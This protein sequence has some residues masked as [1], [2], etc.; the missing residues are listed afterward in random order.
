MVIGLFN[1]KGGVGKTTCAVNLAYAL[2]AL[3]QKVALLDCDRQRQSLPFELGEIPIVEA[4][5]RDEIESALNELTGYD[6]VLVDCPPSLYEAAPVVPFCD[7]I[8]APVPPRFQ[9]L[10]GLAD[11]RET[12]E[13]ARER[14]NEKL[15]LKI[16]VTMRD[17]RV[18]LQNEYEEML[19]ETFGESVL[20][21]VI[22]R[23][24]AFERSARELRSIL[25]SA[26]SSPGAIAFKS[27]ATEILG[28]KGGKKTKK[29]K[30][31]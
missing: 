23:A 14:A 3:N 26:P 20:N 2:S 1:Q 24:A 22:P 13:A 31:K 25:Q 11:L 18:A 5:E 15:Q 8:L 16:V 17:A 12:V 7:V 21:T 27:L 6:F 28:W 10:S 4:L 19:R 29:A 9:D 30:V